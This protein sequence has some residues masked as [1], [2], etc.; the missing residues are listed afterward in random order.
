[1][2]S[3]ATFAAFNTS[4]WEC[5]E[6]GN[7]FVNG[8]APSK[9]AKD[10]VMVNDKN[11]ECDLSEKDG[12]WFLKLSTN[13]EMQKNKTQ[14][15]IS[16]SMLGLAKVPQLPYENVDGSPLQIDTDYFG[17]KRNSKTPFPGPI[18]FIK[19]GKQMVKV[20]PK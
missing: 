14:K 19:D 4:K 15:L 13:A 2:V 20:W 11:F 8:A 6:S 10:S 1:V 9:W 17:K 18:E 12:E 5:F 3:P 7:V 16:T